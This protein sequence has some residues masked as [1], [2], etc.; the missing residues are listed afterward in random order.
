MKKLFHVAR[1][2][3]LRHIKRRGFVW[4]VI[5]L[6][7]IMV[8][9]VGGI[10]FFLSGGGDEPI[11]VVDN[12]GVM[13]DIDGYTSLYEEDLEIVR[14]EDE[15]AARRALA[16]ETVQAFFVVSPDYL[17]SGAVSVYHE[18][19][20]N[21][22]IYGTF[23]RYAR[24]SLLAGTDSAVA[25]RFIDDPLDVEFISLS[26][27]PSAGSPVGFL[28]PFFFGF[29][30]V[31][32]IFTTGGYLLQAVVDEKE[33]RTMEIMAT[34]IKPELMMIGKLVGLVALGLVQLSI[35][36]S[37]GVALVL[38]LKSRIPELDVLTFPLE[39]AVIA[40]LWFIPF[41]LMIASMWSAIGLMVTEVSEGQ[42]ALGI[43]S[44]L[45]M[46]P[47]WLF[48][49]F[50]ESPNSPLAVIFSMIP[51]TS[52][53][54]ILIRQGT[55]DVPMWQM[56]TSWAIL[57]IT[58]VLAVLAV[59]RMLRIGMLRYGQRVTLREFASNLRS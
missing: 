17:D 14:F 4:A 34:S 15:E 23:N 39:T 16:D 18:G 38:F 51:F 40:L 29:M 36:I 33:N 2:E 5:G 11:G 50:L 59:S 6:P 41:Y 44:L 1:F 31:M 22:D 54:T 37:G 20:P 43:I 52:P 7:S 28:L 10:I 25:E 12:S 27:D 26:D 56:V 45:T 3:F 42:Q 47:L 48:A 9:I 53:L 32:A 57:I 21:E 24:T 8:L 55:A 35:W 19:N 58:A 30:F 49:L 13:T 46:S